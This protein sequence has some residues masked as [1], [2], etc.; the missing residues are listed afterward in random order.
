MRRSMPALVAGALLLAG[1]TTRGMPR[2]QAQ[3][4]KGEF[5]YRKRYM[6][7]VVY[8]ND[9]IP[10]NPMP[11]GQVSGGMGWGAQFRYGDV[12]LGRSAI[13]W[14]DSKFL[15]RYDKLV[16]GHD[17]ATGMIGICEKECRPQK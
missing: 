9:P 13:W 5:R 14:P 4:L 17:K 10:L 16:Y 12:E 7:A 15:D 1:C 8:S 3:R 11:R 6:N 2:E